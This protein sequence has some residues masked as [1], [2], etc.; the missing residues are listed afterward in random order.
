MHRGVGAVKTILMIVTAM[1]VFASV[2]SADEMQM[3]RFSSEGL[4][5]WETKNFKGATDYTL[6]KEEGRTV[7]RAVS[8]NAAS[9]LI[10]KFSF[11]PE[12]Y[13]YLRWSWKISRT[14]PGGDEKIRSGDDY[15]ARIYLIF[16]GRFFWQTKAVNYIWANRLTKG[17]SAANAFTSGAMMIAVESGDAMAGQWLTEQRDIV[18]DYRLLFGSEPPE[19]KAIAIMTDTDNTG[20]SAEA[21]YGEI[22]LATEGK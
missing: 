17:A 15:A 2:V 12:K 8:W 6:V 11:A 7:V 3:S 20:A 5:G 18:A 22:S 16:P 1:A 19:G 21:W 10:R 14:I 9:G 13:R 4:A